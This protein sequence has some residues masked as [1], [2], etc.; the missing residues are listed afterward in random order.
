M[1]TQAELAELVLTNAVDDLRQ[2]LNEHPDLVDRRVKQAGDGTLLI[3]A[4]YHGKIG[5]VRELLGRQPD[6]ITQDNEGRAALHTACERGHADCAQAVLEAL[7]P[8]NWIR[9]SIKMQTKTGWS[10]PLLAA[11]SGIIADVLPLLLEAEPD[12]DLTHPENGLTA[13]MCS[14]S[15]GDAAGVQAL[16]AAH[17]NLETR[18]DKDNDG[19]TALML[20]AMEGHEEVAKCLVLAGSGVDTQTQNSLDTAAHLACSMGHLDLGKWLISQGNSGEIQDTHGKLPLD[21]M[22]PEP[23]A[24]ESA[25]AAASAEPGAFG[26]MAS[27]E[28]MASPDAELRL[29]DRD[30]SP[31]QPTPPLLTRLVQAGDGPNVCALLTGGVQVNLQ[32]E[33]GRT[34]LHHAVGGKGAD[35]Q[36]LVETLLMHGADPQIRDSDGMTALDYTEDSA[37]LQMLSPEHKEM[38]KGEIQLQLEAMA[39]GQ[40]MEFLRRLF[41]TADTNHDGTLDPDEMIEALQWAGFKLGRDELLV[42]IQGADM[43]HDGKLSWD[44][45]VPAIM[46]LIFGPPADSDADPSILEQLLAKPRTEFEEAFQAAGADGNCL[47]QPLQLAQLLSSKGFDLDAK[48]VVELVVSANAVGEA[49]IG[50]GV[51]SFREALQVASP[52]LRVSEERAAAHALEQRGTEK[53]QI[54]RVHTLFTTMDAEGSG[55]IGQMDFLELLSAGVDSEHALR[56]IKQCELK[57]GECMYLSVT[58][59]A[60]SC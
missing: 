36:A 8:K 10:V 31:K 21:Y 12:L 49:Q 1:A 15:R 46:S 19:K 5:I 30:N 60:A 50:I 52:C 51:D 55:A 45:F 41:N 25:E 29:S 57:R 6:L 18:N 23:P 56:M 39:P 42:A 33:G 16:I 53:E 38:E 17:S 34:A 59:P 28:R 2:R 40:R 24:P 43:D 22:E 54:E 32:D 26:F 47:L 4:C 3:F 13:L 27:L 48:I 44:E 14:A 9:P 58:R 11:R 37:I 7:K 20:A 35:Q